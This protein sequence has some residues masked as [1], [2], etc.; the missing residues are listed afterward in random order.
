MLAPKP[1]PGYLAYRDVESGPSYLPSPSEGGAQSKV[2]PIPAGAGD[3]PTEL[4]NLSG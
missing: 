3:P 1:G 2:W 4:D